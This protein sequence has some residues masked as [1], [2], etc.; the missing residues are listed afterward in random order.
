MSRNKKAAPVEPVIEV[1]D[2]IVET[3]PV[4]EPVLADALEE[5]P[6]VIEAVVYLGPAIPKL[7]NHG[8]VFSDGVIPP[9]L[10]AKI[11]KIP[12]IKGLIVPVS[13]Y[14]ESERALKVPGRLKTLYEAVSGKL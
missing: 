13:R 14:A 10:E 9:Y 2:P 7:I 4:D 3:A 6:E 8:T 12:A 5:T 1:Q 11:S